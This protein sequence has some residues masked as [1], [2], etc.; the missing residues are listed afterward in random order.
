MAN[1]ILEMPRK[2]QK[3]NRVRGIALTRERFQFIFKHAHDLEE[4][5]EKGF[6][7]FDDW[8]LAVERW[9]EHPPPSFLQSVQIWMQIKNIPVNHYTKEAISELGGLIGHVIEVA[10]DPDKPQRQDYVRVK[11][12]LDVSKPLKKSRILNLPGGGQTTILYFYE[13]VQRRCTHCQR[14][15]H[16]KDR[17]PFLAHQQDLPRNITPST[18]SSHQ[19][20]VRP[21]LSETDP[22]FGVLNENQVG[23]N[24]STG[25]PKINSEVLQE[26]RNYLLAS[27]NEDRLIR[28]QR[29]ISSVREAEKDPII[30]KTV[31]QLETPPSFTTDINKGKGIVFGY[32]TDSS[33]TQS[34]IK[35][36][37]GPKLMAEAIQSA[38]KLDHN[39]LDAFSRL[40][41]PCSSSSTGS[42]T[43]F[44]SSE[45]SGASLNKGKR[46]RRPGKFT[47][48]ARAKQGTTTTASSSK[49]PTLK[50]AGQVKRKAETELAGAS[51][52]AQSNASK[53]V[54]SGG[55]S[56]V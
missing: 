39:D 42:Q 7:T 9:V 53:T 46:R 6:H 41:L 28:E 37:Q 32:D 11:I 10:F 31:L 56:N 19:V 55:P 14:L 8:G 5:L 22:L 1:L 54:P 36:H 25:R 27:S 13:K 45:I 44:S 49:N 2:W 17:C 33:S 3:N 48:I 26:M 38:R 51:K 15:T 30:R 34:T 52:V 43:I 20:Q 24:S 21:I 18:S 16:A 4:V 50:V 47:R 40:S 12:L 29:V 35:D 23:I